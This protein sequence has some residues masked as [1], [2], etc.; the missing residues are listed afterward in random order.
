MTAM[1]S[2]ASPLH[3]LLPALIAVVALGVVH[4]GLPALVLGPALAQVVLAL[5]VAERQAGRVGRAERRRL[6]H[7]RADDRHAE[8]VGL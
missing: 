5:P 2:P 6:G 4:V 1:F 8:H 7:L 3:R